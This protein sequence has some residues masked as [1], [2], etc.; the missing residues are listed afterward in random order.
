MKKKFYPIIESMLALLFFALMLWGL[1]KLVENKQSYTKY[2]EFYKYH[3]QYD[4]LFAGSSHMM[5]MVLPMEL[6]KDHGIRSYNI[7]NGAETL[8]ITY[9]VIRNALDTCTPKVIVLDVFYAYSDKKVPEISK[10]MPHQFFDLVPLS[11]TK[12]GSVFDLFSDAGDRWNYLY[13]FSIYHSRWNELSAADLRPEDEGLGGARMI[14][15]SYVPNDTAFD[16]PDLHAMAK[17]SRKY[18]GMIKELC[19]EQGVRLICVV[20]PYA[21]WQENKLSNIDFENE[22]G[23]LG[24]EFVDLR[25][26]GIV[27]IFADSADNM[28][29]NMNGQR[30]VT[31]FYGK[32]LSENAPEVVSTPSENAAY[33]D[34]WNARYDTYVD[35]KAGFIAATPDCAALLSDLNDPDLTFEITLREGTPLPRAI[36]LMLG[37]AEGNENVSITY[38]TAPQDDI[39]V[40]VRR[41]SDAGPGDIVTDKSFDL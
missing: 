17:L 33:D 2:N 39:R 35:R 9:H 30:K 21:M 38:D 7:G 15:A 16:P 18:L 40:I 4:V 25:D 13:D 23:Q 20:N 8:P 41:R 6:W 10:E 24:I 29:L 28:H 27:D 31:G 5:N 14:L 12:I 26:A 11:A 22:M 19:D 36:E 37:N 3:D 34:I 1:A 32:Y